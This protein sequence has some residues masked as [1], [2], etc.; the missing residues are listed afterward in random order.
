MLYQGWT[1]GTSNKFD[2][3]DPTSDNAGLATREVTYK[4]IKEVRLIGR[5]HQVVFHQEKLIPR[6]VDV[7]LRLRPT[8]PPFVLLN[9]APEGDAAQPNCKVNIRSAKLYFRTC[10]KL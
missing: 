4:Q 2:V 10:Y 7:K 6:V 9:A 1:K 3:P 8:N 5:Q